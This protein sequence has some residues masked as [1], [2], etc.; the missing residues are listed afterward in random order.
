M[1][2]IRPAASGEKLMSIAEGDRSNR[3]RKTL[4]RR[5]ISWPDQIIPDRLGF[6]LDWK[7]SNH[8]AD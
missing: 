1:H 8:E 6:T 5:N 4:L 3:L 2:T 7:A